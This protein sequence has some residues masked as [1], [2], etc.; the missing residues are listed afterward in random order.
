MKSRSHESRAD[1]SLR[2]RPATVD[3]D[4]SSR[5]RHLPVA[6]DAGMTLDGVEEYLIY[7]TTRAEIM[8]Y[9]N[10]SYGPAFVEDL[11][12]HLPQLRAEALNL[13]QLR[14]GITASA[15]VS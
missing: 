15:T 4:S 3:K 7:R 1:D 9:L 8:E 5:G 2:Y 11:I 12:K 10:Q 6:P 14:C 13:A